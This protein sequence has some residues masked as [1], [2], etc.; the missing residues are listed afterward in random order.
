MPSTIYRGFDIVSNGGIWQIFERGKLID[1]AAGLNTAYARI[2]N[3]LRERRCEQV[4][5][6]R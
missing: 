5:L 3:L 4:D 1:D 2:D 6:R